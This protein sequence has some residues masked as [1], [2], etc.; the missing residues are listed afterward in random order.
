[1]PSLDA[2]DAGA[3]RLDDAVDNAVLQRFL[4]VKVLV[5]VKVVLNL[6]AP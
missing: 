1:M 4:G 5:A 6:R 3:G 2:Q